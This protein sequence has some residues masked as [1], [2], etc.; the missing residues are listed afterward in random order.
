MPAS[1]KERSWCVPKDQRLVGTPS[2]LLWLNGLRCR[3]TEAGNNWATHSFTVVLPLLPVR[4]TTGPLN[5]ARCARAMAC[6]K[7]STSSTTTTSLLDDHVVWSGGNW[8]TTNLL[9][10]CAW[11]ASRWSCP[12][13][14]GPRKAKNTAQSGA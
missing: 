1:T 14:Q 13:C 6:K 11:A 5:L 7:S 8:F 9:T 10:P 3:A 2:W 4:A 12:S